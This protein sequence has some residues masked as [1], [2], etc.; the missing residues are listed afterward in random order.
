M[1]PAEEGVEA[2]VQGTEIWVPNG[3]VL[4]YHSGAYGGRSEFARVSALKTFRR[5]EGL[6]GTVWSTQRPHVWTELGAHFV[7]A[8]LAAA[9]GIEAAM[10]FP[11]FD[12]REL[13]AVV[14]LLCGERDRSGGCVEVWDANHDLSLLEHA[15]GYYGRLQRFGELS[16]LLQFQAGTGLPGLALRDG[17][18]QLVDNEGESNAFVRA[19][20]ARDFGIESGIAIPI[21]RDG[22]VEHVLVLLSAEATPIARVFE[23][24]V[25]RGGVLSL[26]RSRYS[27]GLERFAEAS[28]GITFRKGEGLPGRALESGLPAVCDDLRVPPLARSDAAAAAG[29]TAGAAIPVVANGAVQAVACLLS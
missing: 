5:G 26:A 18:P 11:L 10:G 12:G 4:R 23:V 24:W 21:H 6:P 29:L 17:M 8:E 19:S 16:R 2:F 20:M 22:R 28:R 14:V 3:E 7:R 15:G 1:D 25:P 9:S 13:T 27:K